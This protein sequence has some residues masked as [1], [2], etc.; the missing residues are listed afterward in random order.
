MLKKR[1]I[2]ELVKSLC[3][4]DFGQLKDYKYTHFGKYDE[5]LRSVSGRFIDGDYVKYDVYVLGDGQHVRISKIAE[6]DDSNKTETELIFGSLKNGKYTY[7]KE[8]TYIR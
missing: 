4:F 8:S 3:D 2:F 6:N 7:H 5:W 1:K